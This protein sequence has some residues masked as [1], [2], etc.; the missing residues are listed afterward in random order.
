MT[1]ARGS[2]RGDPPAAVDV[3]APLER[4]WHELHSRPEGLDER[5]AARRLQ[6][7][8]PN[9]LPVRGGPAWP[10]ALGRQLVHPLALLLWAAAGL[11]LLAGTPVL[12]AAVVVVIALNAGLA[13][14]QEQH[15]EHAVAALEAYL[16]AHTRVLRGGVAR[17]VPA[18]EIVPGDVVLLA[19]GAAVPADGRLVSGGVEVDM[20]ALTGESV[21]VERRA[22]THPPGPALEAPDLVFRG[23]TCTVGSARA[24][25]TGTGAH[26]EIGRIAA[27]TGHVRE[28]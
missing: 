24:L 1:A 6:V 19:E 15:A 28:R 10:R 8:G 2:R 27:L 7:H 14:W 9:A 25:V 21:A 11:A 12:A 26:T 4:L 20:S 18:A 3:G 22:G 5:D 13:F 23:T 17:E 16:P